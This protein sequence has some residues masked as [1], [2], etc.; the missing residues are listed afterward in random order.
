[1]LLKMWP[2]LICG[3]GKNA[4]LFQQLFQQ[5]WTIEDAKRTMREAVTQHVTALLA[6]GDPIPQ[7]ERLVHVEQMAIGIP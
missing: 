5:R 1:M 3:A 4:R 2:N 6:E 7:N